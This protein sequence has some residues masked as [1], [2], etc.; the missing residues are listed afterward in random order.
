MGDYGLWETMECGRLWPVGNYG[1]WAPMAYPT[2]SCGRQWLTSQIF[3]LLLWAPMA[4]LTDVSPS[5]QS[6]VPY[7]LTYLLRDRYVRHPEFSVRLGGGEWSLKYF[8]LAHRRLRRYLRLCLRHVCH[9]ISRRSES[10]S[11]NVREV[12]PRTSVPRGSPALRRHQIFSC[13][14]SLPL[15]PP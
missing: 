2:F 3:T 10:L 4:G 11:S 12:C 6:I 7:T 1:L 5:P 13:T 9:Q 8:P 15:C 14:Y